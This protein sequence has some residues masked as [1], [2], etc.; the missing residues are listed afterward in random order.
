MA[1][2]Q[3]LLGCNLGAH[4]GHTVQVSLPAGAHVALSRRSS[5]RPSARRAQVGSIFTQLFFPDFLSRRLSN[6]VTNDGL[7]GY[8]AI[9]C[10]FK[11]PLWGISTAERSGRSLVALPCVDSRRVWWRGTETG[12]W[13][14]A[15]VVDPDYESG[16]VS[17]LV[18]SFGA[19]QAPREVTGDL[20]AVDR[21]G[22]TTRPGLRE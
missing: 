3:R 12:N 19:G 9:S 6:E 4:M 2:Q 22:S 15:S 18:I 7:Y 5:L 8:Q 21:A 1:Q 10:G 16:L 11:R 17:S 20:V 13:S 14:P